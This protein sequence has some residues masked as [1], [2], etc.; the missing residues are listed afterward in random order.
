MLVSN[1]TYSYKVL[2]QYL[3]LNNKITSIKVGELSCPTI[4]LMFSGKDSW[5]N[6]KNYIEIVGLLEVNNLL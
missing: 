4:N 2:T 6:D 5:G 3:Q 1:Y